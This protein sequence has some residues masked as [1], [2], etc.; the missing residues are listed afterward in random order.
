MNLELYDISRCSLFTVVCIINA[1]NGCEYLNGPRPSFI[2][3]KCYDESL[4]LWFLKSIKL[5]RHIYNFESYGV[6][7]Y[8]IIAYLKLLSPTFV[9]LVISNNIYSYYWCGAIFGNIYFYENITV[10]YIKKQCL[11]Y[12]KVG[13]LTDSSKIIQWGQMGL[14]CWLPIYWAT[15]VLT[16]VSEWSNINT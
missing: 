8:Q 7:I 10:C 1:R 2:T 15:T 9:L 14:T 13:S 6:W 5:H 12:S 3:E 11:V 4:E 16:I